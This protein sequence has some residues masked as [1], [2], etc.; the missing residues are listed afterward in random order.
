MGRRTK[1]TVQIR[2]T[3]CAFIELGH[4]NKDAALLSG[5]EERTLYYWLERGRTAK[6]GIYFQ[7][8]QSIDLALARFKDKHLQA[9]NKSVFESPTKRVN[10]IKETLDAKGNS[11]GKLTEERE[12]LLPPSIEGSKFLL[13]RRFPKEFGRQVDVEHSGLMGAGPGVTVNLIFDDG[14][15]EEK[16]PEPPV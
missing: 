13:E 11:L 3:I 12:E 4:T 8:I 15:G 7:F 16:E 14:E 10:H 9:I 6:R 5:I 2:D 1:L